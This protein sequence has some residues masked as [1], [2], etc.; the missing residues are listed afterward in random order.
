ML[1]NCLAL[2]YYTLQL[3]SSNKHAPAWSLQASDLLI[4]HILVQMLSCK[5]LW[6]KLFI[7][8]VCLVHAA[9]WQGGFD[10]LPHP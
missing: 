3:S 5:H 6:H 2:S 4:N 10:A 1:V 9:S 8:L 7:N